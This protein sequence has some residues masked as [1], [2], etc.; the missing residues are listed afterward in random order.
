MGG[1]ITKNVTLQ[2]GYNQVSFQCGSP[3][4]KAKQ[5]HA[6]LSR[7]VVVLSGFSF[8]LLPLTF[9]NN[10]NSHLAI[11]NVYVSAFPCMGNTYINMLFWGFFYLLFVE[12]MITMYE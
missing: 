6:S 11:V 12:F 9:D 5:K 7:F 1:T 10:F 4:K 2:A 8:G 3:A